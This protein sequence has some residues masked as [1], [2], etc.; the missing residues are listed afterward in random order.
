MAGKAPKATVARHSSASTRPS[1]GS[2]RGTS[3]L[4]LGRPCR[5]NRGTGARPE[6]LVLEEG[7]FV[8]GWV[9]M[10]SNFRWTADDLN[11]VRSERNSLST[12]G[13][14]SPD[15]RT[16]RVGARD[17]GRGIRPLDRAGRLP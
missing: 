15:Y 10:P 11:E 8:A 12:V 9:A 7:D 2:W 6:V 16:G 4:D 3:G 17:D 14:A 1:R 5:A 13:V